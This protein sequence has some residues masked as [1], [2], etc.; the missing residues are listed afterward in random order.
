MMQIRQDRDR[1]RNRDRIIGKRLHR[2]NLR[3]IGI[4][5]IIPSSSR[6]TAED[7]GLWK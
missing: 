4:N 7:R 1:D 2:E 6:V 3:G 5:R